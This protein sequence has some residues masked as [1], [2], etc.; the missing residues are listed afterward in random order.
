LCQPDVEVRF[1]ARTGTLVS[2][3]APAG[4]SGVAVEGVRW[5][6]CDSRLEPLSGLGVSNEAVGGEVVVR[7]G[8]GALVVLVWN[9][10]R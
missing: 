8:A 10:P 2:V 9:T 3:L 1:T 7:T 5:P 6:L 4:A